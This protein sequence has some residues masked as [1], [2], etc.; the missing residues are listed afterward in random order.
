MPTPSSAPLPLVLC[1]E[2]D[3]YFPRKTLSGVPAKRCPDCR[4]RHHQTRGSKYNGSQPIIRAR[5]LVQEAD[6]RIRMQVASTVLAYTIGIPEDFAESIIS[7]I[8][9]LLELGE[10]PIEIRLRLNP[11]PRLIDA[12]PTT[13]DDR[14]RSVLL[15]ALGIDPEE[16][17]I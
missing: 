11:D 7:V 16:S 13:R 3:T 9:R 10:T 1:E 5:T 12:P 6:P 17:T 15:E 8:D 4:K 2:C 14:I